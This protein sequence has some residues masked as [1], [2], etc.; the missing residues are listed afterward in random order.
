METNDIA[1]YLD[2]LHD[3]LREEDEVPKQIAIAKE[4]WN[5]V[6]TM[7][8][9]DTFNIDLRVTRY[10]VMTSFN[11]GTPQDIINDAN[12]MIE[13]DEFGRAKG[14]GYNWLSR[15][16]GNMGEHEKAITALKQQLSGV[17]SLYE[18]KYEREELEG[19]VLNSIAFHLFEMGK[20]KEAEKYII[21]SYE[22]YPYIDDRNASSGKYFLAEKKLDLAFQF[23]ST[24]MDWSFETQDGQRAEYGKMLHALYQNGELDDHSGLLGMYFYIVR[25]EKELFNIEG[26]L[27]FFD[28]YVPEIEKWLKKYP[29]NSTLWVTLGNTYYYDLE[30]YPKALEA[31][32]KMLEGDN[33]TEFATLERM[34]TAAHEADVDFFSLPLKI[35]G[36]SK[37]LY[38]HLTNAMNLADDEE[39]EDLKNKLY[40]LAAQYGQQGYFQYQDYLVDEKGDNHNNQPHMFSILC[41]NLGYTLAERDTLNNGENLDVKTQAMIGNMTWLG[42]QFSPAPKNL[43][44]ASIAE[45]NAKNYEQSIQLI[46]KYFQEHS[47]EANLDNMQELYWSQV[48]NYIQIDNL[49]MVKNTYTNAKELYTRTGAGVEYATRKFIYTAAQVFIYLVGVKKEYDLAIQEMN[50]F[51]N[52]TGFKK[53]EIEKYGEMYLYLGKAYR[54]KEQKQEACEAYNNCVKTLKGINRFGHSGDTSRKAKTAMLSLGCEK[55]KFGLIPLVSKL[56]DKKN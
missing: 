30:N 31:Y 34:Y 52:E 44:L 42:Y 10:N 18:K 16:Y 40:T 36:R 56:L 6:D 17:P 11:L 48:N 35:E 24:H 41:N 14:I 19:E 39:D 7:L 15:I 4:I 47:G 28:D 43:L 29:T 5:T 49:D 37:H 55:K 27:D 12:F 33:P 23:L 9:E 1:T 20:T 38:M 46:D 32:T 25:N 21:R 50:V 8:E 3:K 26:T 13:H 53:L 22:K 45:N 2:G 54:E 51:F